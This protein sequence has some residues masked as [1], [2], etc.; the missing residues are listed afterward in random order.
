M[1]RFFLMI[2]SLVLLMPFWASAQEDL[3]L[4]KTPN[5]MIIFDT[6]DSMNMSVNVNDRGNSV[7]TNQFGPDK[8]TQYVKDGNHPDS[9]LYQAKRALAQIIDEVVK[10]RIRRVLQRLW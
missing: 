8:V 7:W 10:D 3:F 6:S 2:F 4:V 1:K 9:K 5:V